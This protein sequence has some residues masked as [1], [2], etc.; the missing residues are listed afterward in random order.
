MDVAG[1]NG[2]AWTLALFF[3]AYLLLAGARLF[4]L[5]ARR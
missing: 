2:F 5:P 3:A 1:P 4:A